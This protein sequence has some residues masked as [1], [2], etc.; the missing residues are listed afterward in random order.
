MAAR[1][2]QATWLLSHSVRH[3]YTISGLP[4]ECRRLN[5]FITVADLREAA[6]IE[7]VLRVRP[8][9][10]TASAIILVLLPIIKK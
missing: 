1:K 9:S 7:A 4:S 6:I 3:M 2:Q 5:G 8:K 10:M